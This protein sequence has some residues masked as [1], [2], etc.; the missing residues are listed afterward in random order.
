MKTF[1]LALAGLTLLVLLTGCQKPVNVLLVSGGHDFDTTE[2]FDLFQSL[3]GIEMDSVYYPDAMSLMRSDKTH[4]Y[5]VL[6]F[7]D[8]MVDLPGE[9][10]SVFQN[11]TGQGKPILFLHHAL[12]SFQGWD[13]YMEMLGGKYVIAGPGVDS[14]L[15]SDYKH[16]IEIAIEVVDSQHPVTLGM[17]DFTIHD[18]GYSNITQV[19]GITPLLKT[20]HP[21]CSPL[22]GW[23]KT[24]DQSTVVYLMLGHDKLAYQ[25]PSFKLLLEQSIGWLADQ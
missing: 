7:Y 5:D 4:A 1:S 25:N 14:T 22:I 8:Y 16:D 12:C 6:V 21:D 15:V 9:D 20:E 3:E 2:F 10:S 23:T 11:L 18:E 17:Q 24:S 19:P 13:G